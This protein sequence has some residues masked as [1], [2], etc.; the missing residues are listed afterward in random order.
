[1][2][3]DEAKSEF[4]RL[5]QE[6]GTFAAEAVVMATS[7]GAYF[8]AKPED[9]EFLQCA[10][11]AM[12]ELGRADVARVHEELK[13]RKLDCGVINSSLFTHRA[14]SSMKKM[15]SLLE[16]KEKHAPTDSNTP[17]NLNNWEG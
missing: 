3:E 2:S 13:K 15:L 4:E 7:I 5:R 10:V 8:N 11:N 12:M 17:W 16:K 6:I 9:V 1:M 14:L